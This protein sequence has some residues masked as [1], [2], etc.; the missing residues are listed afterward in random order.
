M[1]SLLRFPVLMFG[2]ALLLI[3]SIVTAAEGT[4]ENPASGSTY[5]STSSIACAGSFLRVNATSVVVKIVMV[6]TG[7]IE[8]EQSANHMMTT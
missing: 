4:I 7:D 2:F 6:D 8:A 3:A 5:T 1:T